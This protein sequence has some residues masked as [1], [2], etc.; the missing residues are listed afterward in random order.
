M[1]KNV[2]VIAFLLL[3]QQNILAQATALKAVIDAEGA[4]NKLVAKKGIKDAFLAVTD[5]EAIVFRPQ[6]V[7]AKAFYTS[8]EKQPGLLTWEPKFARISAN[9]DLAFT[10]GPYTYQNNKTDTDKVF[11]HYVSIWR[12]DS[13]K[14]LKILFDLGVQHPESETEE[15][16]DFKEPDASKV[17]PPST[18]PFSNK[19]LILT[20]DKVFNSTLNLSTLASYKEFLSPQGHYYFPGYEPIVGQDS[21]L[22]FIKSEGISINA[23]T[24][25]AGRAASNDLA[26]TYGTAKITKGNLTADYNYVRIWEL[27]PGDKWNILLEVFA[28]IEN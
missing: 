26:Y 16:T 23:V 13:E 17:A 4:F 8:I 18:D 6:A 19:K 10:A 2:I 7:N 27:E 5:D 15:A 20:T 12:A 14:K 1:K 21:V 11:G 28:A 24:T 25:S 3:T 22:R 9:G